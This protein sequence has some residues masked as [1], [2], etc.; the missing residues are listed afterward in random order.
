MSYVAPDQK[1]WVAMESVE[2]S[3]EKDELLPTLRLR[4]E[5]RF[6]AGPLVLE[7]LETLCG[8]HLLWQDSSS[9]LIRI[10]ADRA[11]ALRVREGGLWKG[12]AIHVMVHEEQVTMERWSPDGQRVA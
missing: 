7:G 12:V 3:P 4:L 6:G 1:H 11:Q 9:L 2:P 10:G 5:G 8:T